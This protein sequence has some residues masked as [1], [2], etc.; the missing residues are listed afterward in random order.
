MSDEITFYHNPMSRGRMVHWMLEETGA[1][2]KVELVS[3]E[4]GENKSSQNP[5][6]QAHKKIQAA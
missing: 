6:S 5:R 4:K 3:F 2:Y 1:P